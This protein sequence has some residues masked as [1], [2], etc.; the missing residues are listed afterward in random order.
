MLAEWD[1]RKRKVFITKNYNNYWWNLSSWRNTSCNSCSSPRPDL[2]VGCQRTLFIKQA[3]AYKA[4]LDD[5]MQ[6]QTDATEK[7][8]FRILM[9]NDLKFYGELSKGSRF[10]GSEKD[11][12]LMQCL[13]YQMLLVDLLT[14]QHH[15]LMLMKI[16]VFNNRN[17]WRHVDEVW[18]S[19]CNGAGAAFK[20]LSAMDQA[21]GINVNTINK[22]E[23]KVCRY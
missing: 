9:L 3:A 21:L 7:S 8:F 11:L 5:M 1:A 19:I 18:K 15:L 4:A 14:L 2:M 22:K 20:G 6:K 16:V 13:E 10:K 17:G 12:I 23:G